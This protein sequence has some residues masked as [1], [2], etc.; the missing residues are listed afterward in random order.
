MKKTAVVVAILSLFLSACVKRPPSNVDNICKIFKQY[1]DWYSAAR[2]TQRKWG[3]PMAV[4][5]AIIHQESR[6]NGRAKPARKKLLWVIPWRRPSSAYGYTQALNS[7]WE[8]YK[9]SR[10]KLWAS[11]NDFSDGVD[12]IGWYASTAHK[13][14]GISKNNAYALYLAYHEGVGGY[15]RKTYL[16]KKWLIHVAHKVSARAKKYQSQLNRCQRYLR[17]KAWYKLW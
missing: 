5:M 11:R 10:G 13:R 1:P 6:F 15:M 9:K 16:K 12:F 14:A 3:V 2:T 7:T 8:H 4:Q 17:G